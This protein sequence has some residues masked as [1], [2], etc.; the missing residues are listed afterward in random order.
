MRTEV[1]LQR[2]RHEYSTS[3]SLYVKA[4]SA[5]SEEIMGYVVWDPPSSYVPTPPPHTLDNV[6]TGSQYAIGADRAL[7]RSMKQEHDRALKRVTEGAEHWYLS[8]IVVDPNHQG[9]GVGSALLKWGTKRADKNGLGVF[10]VSSAE[11]SLD[12]CRGTDGK[13]W[14]MYSRRGFKERLWC[15]FFTE[16]AESI[17]ERALWREPVQ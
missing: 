17:R 6:I 4:T 8:G 1:V 15:H 5:G 7:F 9:K 13:G 16:K 11:V 3:T 14:E 10:C 2:M 12:P